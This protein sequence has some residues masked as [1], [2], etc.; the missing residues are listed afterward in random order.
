MRPALLPA[1]RRSR[2]EDRMDPL[3]DLLARFA[4]HSRLLRMWPLRGGVSAH[5]DAV[6]LERPGGSVQRVVV[7]R[8]GAIDKGHPADIGEREHRLLGALSALGMPVPEPL[9]AE[10]GTLV[11]SFVDGTTEL[12][13]EEWPEATRRMADF[14]ADLHAVDPIG[15]DFL[16]VRERPDLLAAEYVKE[17]LPPARGFARAS[18]LHGDYWPG[19]VMWRDG[20]IAAVLD[21]EDAAVGDPLCDVAQGRMELLW[22][23]DAAVMDTFTARYRERSGVDTAD[24]PLWE[25]Y[26][27]SAGLKHMGEWGLPAEQERHMRETTTAFIARAWRDLRAR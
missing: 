26:V 21:W 22:K 8:H 24:L 4:P 14:L 9:W 15:L 5:V 27:A 7:R 20:R 12:R 23:Y 19:N 10:G 1:E 13:R 18:L 25:L 6:E 17:P 16:P 3:T 2:Y 11:T